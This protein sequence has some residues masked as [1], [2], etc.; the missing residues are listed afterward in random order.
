[1]VQS[2]SRSEKTLQA[3]AEV[4]HRATP[5]ASMP[6]S[7]TNAELVAAR[8]KTN[9]ARLGG[10]CGVMPEF[11]NV[12]QSNSARNQRGSLK[13]V[14]LGPTVSASLNLPPGADQEMGNP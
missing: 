11:K 14:L 10:P 3:S 12:G 4:V 2:I 6:F 5:R 1:M 8:I 7:G 13:N 9:R